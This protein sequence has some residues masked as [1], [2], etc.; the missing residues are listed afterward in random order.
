MRRADAADLPAL[1]AFLSRHADIAMFPL[2]NL[3]SE[4]LARDGAA[5]APR[6]MR[7]WIAGGD[8]PTGV[9][10]MT[11][12]G[13]ILPVLP[14]DAESHWA[15][16]APFLSGRRAMGLAGEAQ[17]ARKGMAVLGLRAVGALNR[18]EPHFALD[19]DALIVPGGD[20][21][22]SLRP[23]PAQRGLLEDWRAAYVVETLGVPAGKG[24]SVA[25]RDVGRMLDLDSHRIL[26]LA[27]EPV[28]MAGIN[29][30]VGDIVQIGGVYTPEHLRRRGHARRAVA[31][32]LDEKRRQ[33]A[34]RAVL[35][36]AT[37]AAAKA[38]VA[39]G[40]RRIGDY[41]LALFDPPVKIAP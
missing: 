27:G 6:S 34:R 15:S 26:T 17:A 35:F 4:G 25:R 1:D 11:E 40:F 41:T 30:G 28:S 14:S 29:A 22:A 20:G 19:L 38:Y 12:E 32:L 8:I 33:G 10:A 16:A 36:A 7:V 37:A 18:D 31:H 39:I 13:M 9:V 2:S 21:F 23:G 5:N 3:R 24:P